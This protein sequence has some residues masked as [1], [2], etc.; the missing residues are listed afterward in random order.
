MARHGLWHR[1]PWHGRSKTPLTGMRHAQCIRPHARVLLPIEHISADACCTHL[2]LLLHLHPADPAD[3]ACAAFCVAL[4]CFLVAAVPGT[5]FAD[6][7]G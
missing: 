1:T 2:L 3:E 6:S 7:V 4:M 5:I